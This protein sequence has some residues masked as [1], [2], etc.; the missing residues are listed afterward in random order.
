[1]SALKKHKNIYCKL[2]PMSVLFPLSVTNKSKQ[3]FV[4]CRALK[5]TQIAL[6]NKKI[7]N[8]LIIIYL[9]K[10]NNQNN[11]RVKLLWLNV[12]INGEDQVNKSEYIYF[13]FMISSPNHLLD[14]SINLID[15]SNKALER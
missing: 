12:K 13:S 8:I 2:I 7:Y 4:I 5:D 6:I 1:M 9:N 15:D 3:I 11:I 14:F 10:T